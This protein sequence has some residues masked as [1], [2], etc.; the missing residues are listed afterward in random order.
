MTAF[1]GSP[2]KSWI[3][4]KGAFWRRRRRRRKYSRAYNAVVSTSRVTIRTATRITGDLRAL[5]ASAER[6]LF[7][8]VVTFAVVDGEGDAE[9]DVAVVGGGVAKGVEA[10][11]ES[12]GMKVM[13]GEAALPGVP[14]IAVTASSISVVETGSVTESS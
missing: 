5:I 4:V 9:T 10:G 2:K 1:F 8:A 6:L 13:V 7:R 3:W 12:V 11:S 14:A